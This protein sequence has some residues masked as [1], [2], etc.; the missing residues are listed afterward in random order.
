MVAEIVMVAINGCTS[1]LACENVMCEVKH[2]TQHLKCLFI[3]N[4]MSDE[5][6]LPPYVNLELWRIEARKVK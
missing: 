2:L 6:I 3:R 4:T 1:N 5:A